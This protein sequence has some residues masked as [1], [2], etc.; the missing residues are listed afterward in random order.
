MYDTVG[1]TRTTLD[2]TSFNWFG[3]FFL[4]LGVAWLTWPVWTAPFLDVTLAR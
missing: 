4:L 2:W 1:G 3:L